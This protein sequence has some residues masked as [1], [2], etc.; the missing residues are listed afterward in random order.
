MFLAGKSINDCSHGVTMA[1][2]VIEPPLQ[3][4]LLRSLPP[5][6]LPPHPTPCKPPRLA[7]VRTFLSATVRI[8]D[9]LF[10]SPLL[11]IY[12]IARIGP[13]R[14]LE[15]MYRLG[16][17]RGLFPLILVTIPSTWTWPIPNSSPTSPEYRWNPQIVPSLGF[18]IMYVRL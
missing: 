17:M 6:P 9:L 13:S 7:T 10:P 12:P 15:I 14:M 11:L 1:P 8:T 4:P 5:A 3:S 16:R 2:P 18:L